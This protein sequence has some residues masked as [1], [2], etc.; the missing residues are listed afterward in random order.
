MVLLLMG[1]FRSGSTSCT[2]KN[3]WF[4]SYKMENKNSGL[5]HVEVWEVILKAPMD[6]VEP[7]CNKY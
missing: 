2:F 1:S 6:L 5:Q 4:G 3:L 7:H